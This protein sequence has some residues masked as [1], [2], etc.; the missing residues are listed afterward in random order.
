VVFFA[1]HWTR[2]VIGFDSFPQCAT[3]LAYFLPIMS[4]NELDQTEKLFGSDMDATISAAWLYYHHDLT[5][6]EIAKQLQVSRPTVANLL[7]RARNQGIVSIALRPDL[8]SRLSLADELR[9]RFGLQN[10]YIVPTPEKAS[11]MEL[12]QALGKAGA[13]LLESTIGSGDVV[14]VAWGV[15]VLEVARAMSGKQIDNVVLTQAIGCLNSGE[16]FNPIRL[17]GIMAEKLG[18]KVYHLPVPA[19]VSSVTIKDILLGDRNIRSCLEMS[20][21][22]SRAMIG[23]GKVNYDATVVSAGFFDPMMMDELKAKGAV[24]DISCRYFDINGNPVITD[25]DSRV[26]SLT[27]DD[28][29]RIKPVIAVG[30]GEDKVIAVLGA[31]RTKCIDILITDERTA[32]KVLTV[33]SEAP[34]RRGDR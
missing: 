3:A 13:L 15:T 33:D 22:A 30:G 14:A 27:F 29:R 31:L 18:A 4:S 21:A 12:R 1:A 23:I 5:Q 11:P 8:L 20:R 6:A 28:L 10:A 17:V 26:I 7:A 32:R 34:A 16:S 19:V 9:G 25:F 24:G 2:G